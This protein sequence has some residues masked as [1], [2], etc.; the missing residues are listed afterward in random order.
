MVCSCN[1]PD[2][3]R[4]LRVLVAARPAWR[5]DR[6]SHFREQYHVRPVRYPLVIGAKRKNQRIVRGYNTVL[7]VLP[8][9]SGLLNTIG[10]QMG[11]DLRRLARADMQE[12]A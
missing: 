11:R 5:S 7:T 3:G 8:R 9:P 12:S 1:H 10:R 2:A 6:R 4:R